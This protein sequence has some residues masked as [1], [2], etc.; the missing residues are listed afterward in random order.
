MKSVRVSALDFIVPSI[1]SEWVSELTKRSEMEALEYF[2]SGLR[3]KLLQ[4]GVN[5]DGIV[6]GFDPGLLLSLGVCKI[7]FFFASPSESKRFTFLHSQTNNL[8]RTRWNIVKKVG[9]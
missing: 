7:V 3:S 5:V 6:F 1:R 9:E 2:S 4:P 8:F